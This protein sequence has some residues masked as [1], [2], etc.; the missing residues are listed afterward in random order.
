MIG[1]SFARKSIGVFLKET[2]L[3]SRD[4]IYRDSRRHGESRMRPSTGSNPTHFR[5]LAH[6]QRK[7]RQRD[8]FNALIVVD[9]ILR[10]FV[11]KAS[12]SVPTISIILKGGKQLIPH[13]KLNM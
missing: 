12:P 8:S 5:E 13:T 6:G 9:A 10:S 3:R 11:V 1:A 2:V 4:A 7:R